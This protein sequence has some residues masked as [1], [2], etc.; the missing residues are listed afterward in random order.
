M[1]ELLLPSRAAAR[2]PSHPTCGRMCIG[3]GELEFAAG[4][5]VSEDL[6]SVVDAAGSLRHHGQDKRESGCC[7]GAGAPRLHPRAR[8]QDI[9]QEVANG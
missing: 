5:V 6:Q 7:R 8:G 3:G 9:E 1:A 2:L 4:H